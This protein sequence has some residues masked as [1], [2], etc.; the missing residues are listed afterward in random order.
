MNQKVVKAVRKA[1]KMKEN[2]LNNQQ[3]KEHDMSDDKNENNKPEN[4]KSGSP[5]SV[6]TGHEEVASQPVQESAV[7]IRKAKL[8]HYNNEAVR[9][10]VNLLGLPEE[11]SYHT[12]EAISKAYREQLR[13]NGIRSS[14]L[15]DGENKS[16]VDKLNAAKTLLT[17]RFDNLSK[18]VT[19]IQ[20]NFR[21]AKIPKHNRYDLTGKQQGALGVLE[22]ARVK[23]LEGKMVKLGSEIAKINPESTRSYYEQTKLIGSLI[24]EQVF[25]S[26]YHEI[27]LKN[28]DVQN[29]IKEALKTTYKVADFKNEGKTKVIKF[30]ELADHMQ[31]HADFLKQNPA[32]RTD[33]ALKERVLALED[34]AKEYKA[35]SDMAKDPRSNTAKIVDRTL[36]IARWSTGLAVA[37]GAVTGAVYGVMGISSAIAAS[38]GV[39]FGVGAGVIAAL[40]MTGYL[41][42]VALV[43]AVGAVLYIRNKEAVDAFVSKN[44]EYM[45]EQVKNL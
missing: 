1:I 6:A 10:A 20:A 23:V 5:T 45:S 44:S 30:I 34:G 37:G 27:F 7:S 4:K 13:K 12:S 15:Q 19:K 9:E 8:R 18:G 31:A 24:K 17:D 40:T 33:S 14:D 41:A 36:N 26:S 39:S 38:G 22:A 25:K 35:W 3:F 43:L 16:L 11:D 32:W 21:G 29:T 42:P 28:E 2:E